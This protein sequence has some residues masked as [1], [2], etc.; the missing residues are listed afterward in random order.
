MLASLH[1]LLLERFPELLA[2]RYLGWLADG[3][4]MTLWI[5]FLAILLST[6]LGLVLAAARTGAGAALGRGAAAYIALFRNTPLLVQL[7]FW[8]FGLPGLLPGGALEWLNTPRAWALGPVVVPWP[9]YEFLA[10]L[11]GLSLYSA[12]FVAEEIR[13]GMQGVPTGQ[14]Q[15]AAALGLSPYQTLR[16]VVLPQAVAI[17]LPPLLGQYMNI[18][19]NSSLTMAIGLVELS[20]A[21]RQVESSTFKTFQSFGA[22]TLLYILAVAAI[23]ALGQGLRQRRGAAWEGR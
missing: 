6:L 10:A 9:A 3:L 23:A 18:V 17:A 11:L 4:G 2:P 7:F 15:A 19:K 8:Y 22:A 12:A 13:A 5:S 21:S 1:S 20:Y 14:R 16:Y